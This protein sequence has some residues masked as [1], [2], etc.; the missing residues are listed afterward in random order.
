MFTL[1]PFEETLAQPFSTSVALE[2]IRLRLLQGALL[3]ADT[4]R[5]ARYVHLQAFRSELALILRDLTPPPTTSM[6]STPF[7]DRAPVVALATDLR[8]NS[9]LRLAVDELYVLGAPG[10][11]R[12]ML[13]PYTDAKNPREWVDCMCAILCLA[14]LLE[15]TP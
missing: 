2:N 12:E 6:L 10:E 4:T 14:K 9:D 13:V 3:P 8:R 7:A 11:Y 15:A 5:S 1:T